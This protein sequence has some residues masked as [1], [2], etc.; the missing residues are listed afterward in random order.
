MELIIIYSVFII[1]LMYSVI[2]NREK[3]K[4]AFMSTKNITVRLLPTILIIVGIVGL[5]LGF[6]PPETIESYLGDEAGFT[7]TAAAGIIGSLVFIPNIVAVPLVGSLLRSGAAVMTAAA[8]LTTLTMVG[9]VTAPVEIKEL[10]KRYTVFR[11][12]LSFV[13]ALLVA[14]VMGI[15]FN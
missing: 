5:L 1:A 7:G 10:G 13:F 9:T 11:N 14:F 12:L 6:V 4:Q 2:M 15:V 3:T 8:F